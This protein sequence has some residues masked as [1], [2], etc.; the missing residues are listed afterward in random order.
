VRVSGRKYPHGLLD[1]RCEHFLRRYLAR[2]QGR[3]PP[4]RGL[5]LGQL[6]QPSLIGLITAH[7]SVSGAAAI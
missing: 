2:H 1:D 4:Q 3:D 7:D 5:L 6:Q